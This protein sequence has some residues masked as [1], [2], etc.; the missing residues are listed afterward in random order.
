MTTHTRP[1]ERTTI[2]RT[3]M[4]SDA[5]FSMVELIVAMA[6]FTVLMV[7]MGAMTVTAYRT[8]S[9]VTDRTDVQARASLAM[10]EATRMLRYTSQPNPTL[11]AI[12]AAT[13]SAITFYT[14]AG[15]GTVGDV[16]YKVTLA[17]AAQTAADVTAGVKRLVATTCRPSVYGAVAG[18][19][20]YYWNTYT[21]GND[22]NGVPYCTNRTLF[23]TP[24][25]AVSPMTFAVTKC[26]RT[27]GVSCYGTRAAVTPLNGVL[28]LT[29]NWVPDTVAI[30]IGDQ[31]DATYVIRQQVG[32]VNSIGQVN[33]G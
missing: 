26:D 24:A 11:N 20:G 21:S 25:S 22:P 33:S 10:E 13:S 19:D 31:R 4:M 29:G 23:T 16:P 12:E 32:L 5:G 6:V 14:F 7:V 15:E 1:A 18:F 8:I 3:P 9:S 2:D 17:T 30:T 28:G 27:A